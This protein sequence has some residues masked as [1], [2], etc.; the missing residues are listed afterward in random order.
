MKKSA[1]VSAYWSIYFLAFFAAHHLSNWWVLSVSGIR[2]GDFIDLNAVL[3]WSDC[4]ENIGTSVYKAPDGACGGYL[5]GSTLLR[6]LDFI[7]VGASQTRIWGIAL[8]VTL[9]V[10]LGV[11]AAFFT[12]TRGVNP[13]MVGLVFSSP[14]IWLLVERGNIDLLIFIMVV[15]ATMLFSRGFEMTSVTLIAATALFKFY[16]L[17]LLLVLA[18][19]SEHKK[20]RIATLTIFLITAPIVISDYLMIQQNFPS[21]WF[22]SFGLPAIGFWINVLSEEFG[23]NSVNLKIFS[24]YFL[25]L[26]LFVVGIAIAKIYIFNQKNCFVPSSIFKRS[27]ALN[28]S[29]ILYSG[30]I[31]ITC[32]LFGMNYDYRLVF[33]SVS[34][35]A[36]LSIGDGIRSQRKIQYL[37]LISLWF[38]S[39]SFG[40]QNVSFGLFMLIQLIGDIS[41]GLFMAIFCLSLG[42]VVRQNKEI[43]RKI[44]TVGQWSD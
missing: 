11:L 31:V 39:F 15:L 6:F 20:Y 21:T 23:F 5:Y 14:P 24:I 18:F 3:K 44:G 12:L 27:Q 1:A 8:G 43:S 37:L 7:G 19:V 34:G 42:N 30:T 35:L 40:L 38:T 4:F 10:C 17:P 29:I 13:I 26:T 33:A 2:G 25:G 36:L 41:L 9:S 22:I 28:D 32:Y 16:T